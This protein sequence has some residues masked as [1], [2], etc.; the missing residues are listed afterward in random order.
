MTRR[1]ERLGNDAC[2]RRRQ[3]RAITLVPTSATGSYPLLAG[4][5]E[6]CDRSDCVVRKAKTCLG[7]E[8]TM[9][10]GPNLHDGPPS[11]MPFLLVA[12]PAIRP[13]SRGKCGRQLDSLVLSP[14][15]AI[16]H[17]G[18]QVLPNCWQPPAPLRVSRAVSLVRKIEYPSWLSPLPRTDYID[19]L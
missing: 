4:L 7:A 10:P 6:A 15:L 13:R 5:T 2:G 9:R 12:E 1:F 11:K 3:R 17:E 16:G 8:L 18:T 19:L 14:I